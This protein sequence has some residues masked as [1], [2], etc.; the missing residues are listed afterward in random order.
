MHKIYTHELLISVKHVQNLLT[1]ANIPCLIKNANAFSGIGA[2]AAFEIWPELWVLNAHDVA[3]AEAVMQ[4]TLQD[5][6][7]SAT[8]HCSNCTE[9][10]EAEFE[11]CWKCLQPRPG[12]T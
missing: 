1:Q 6:F 10:I 7:T 5:R 2:L 9:D 4:N 11:M 12:E 3:E 8:W